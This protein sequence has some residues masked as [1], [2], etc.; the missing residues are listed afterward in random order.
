MFKEPVEILPNVNYTACA[1]LKVPSWGG[2]GRREACED[3]RKQ[4]SS[5]PSVQHAACSAFFKACSII[6]KVCSVVLHLV[7]Q[8]STLTTSVQSWFLVCLASVQ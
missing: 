2:V 5:V 4:N 7:E 6:S 8:W 3:R 1:T